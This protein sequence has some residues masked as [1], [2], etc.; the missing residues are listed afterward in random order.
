MPLNTDLSYPWSGG[1]CQ[2]YLTIVTFPPMTSYVGQRSFG[3]VAEDIQVGPFPSRT[4]PSVV[5]DI[6]SV[7]KDFQ[8][9]PLIFGVDV[10][11]KL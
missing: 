2:S 8:S 5:S 4:I 10:G 6:L 9:V 11:D 3:T 1:V 7:C